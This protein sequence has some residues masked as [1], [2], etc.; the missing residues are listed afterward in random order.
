MIQQV[1][2]YQAVVQDK[3]TNISKYTSIAG[4]AFLFLLLI[5][6]GGW[7]NWQIKQLKKTLQSKQAQLSTVISELSLAQAQYPTQEVNPLLSSELKRLKAVA[8]SLVLV[9]TIPTGHGSDKDIGFSQYFKALAEQSIDS[10][11]L[12][13][14]NINAQASTIGLHGSTYKPDSLATLIKRLNQEAVFQGLYFAHLSM[15]ASENNPQKI[16][17]TI[18]TQQPEK[19][20]TP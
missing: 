5:S 4:L 2:L 16:N 13:E 17:F 19:S 11:W 10:I 15:Q 18:S 6:Y 7:Q 1:N 3:K 12:T 14:I 20:P 8:S 9:A